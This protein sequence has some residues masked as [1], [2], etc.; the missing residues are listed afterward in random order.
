[1]SYLAAA[2]SLARAG[3]LR[4]PFAEWSSRDSTARLRDFAPGFSVA[5]AALETAR[6]SSERSATW[7][8]AASAFTT[9]AGS[10]LVVSAATTPTVGAAA[11]VAVLATPALVQDHT[12][13]LS[14]PLFLALLV[15]VIAL[16]AVERPRASAFGLVAAAAV[17]VRYAGLSLVLAAAARAALG[18][19]TRWR[20]LLAAALAAAPGLLAFVLWNRWAGGVREYGWKGDFGTTLLEGWGTLQEW[21]VPGAPPSRAR[22]GLAVAALAALVWLV[23]RGARM[24]RGASPAAFRLLAAAG[25]VAA[26]YVALLTFSRLFADAAIPFDNRIVSPLFLVATLAAATAIGVQWG[27]MQRG[28]RTAVVIAAGLWCVA[29]ARVTLRELR[30]LRV[31]GWGYASAQWIGSD[32]GKWLLTDGARYELFSDNPPSL[33]SL[34][35]RSSRSLPESIDP[36]TVRRLAEILRDRPSAVIAFQEPDAAPGAR[37]EDFARRLMLQQ[38]FRAA[39]G[40]V[41]V[42]PSAQPSATP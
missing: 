37:G 38:V 6:V 31:D 20:R 39:D 32:L 7:V 35:H 34:T 17:M 40:T 21:L 41:F 18:A 5:I 16:A 1:M 4:V 22:A 11:A 13:V 15:A 14:E 33:Y 42:L 19:A 29:S 10:T 23:A 24:A 25:I 36:Q 3:E 28:L 9:V 26:S 2:D 30:D 27:T 8:E 12:I